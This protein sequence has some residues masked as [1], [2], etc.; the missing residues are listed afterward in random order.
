M[1][2]KKVTQANDPLYPVDVQRVYRGLTDAGGPVAD[3]VRQ[4]R[5][6]KTLQ[7]EA[8][9]KAKTDL[10][11]IV[12]A[13]FTPAVRIKA[14]F[15]YAEHFI[16]DV[17]KIS[18][19]DRSLEELKSDFRRDPRVQLMFTSPGNDG[20][21]LLFRLS[22]RVTDTGLYSTFYRIFASRWAD[23]YGIPTLVDRVTHD[24]SRCCFMSFDPEAYLNH[25]P[26]AID[27]DGYAVMEDLS[28]LRRAELEVEAMAATFGVVGDEKAGTASIPLGED[29]IES[30]RARLLPSL[31]RKK[32]SKEYHQPGRLLEVLPALE[33]SLAEAGI[34]MAEHR[35]IQY[36][37]QLRLTAGPFWAEVN[38]FFG[39]NAFKAVCTTKTGSNPQLAILAR[40][41]IQAFADS[42]IT[43]D[44]SSCLDPGASN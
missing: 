17:D 32:P 28:A 41:A 34:G 39:K 10:P 1:A 35:P 5:A 13:C 19:G 37:R 16:V 27:P 18:S 6:L 40:D 43:D 23:R 25:E 3:K 7:P 2:G 15:A 44:P 26:E 29:V 8:Y 36:G 33:A 30:I 31:S 4:L 22:K 20:I 12:T 24:V 42:F 14:N 21:K 9:R 38:L 11:Y